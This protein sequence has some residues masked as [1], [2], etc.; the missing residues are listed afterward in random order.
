MFQAHEKE[1]IR[2]QQEI[3]IAREQK[4]IALKR[5]R[6][7]HVTQLA[8]NCAFVSK[9]CDGICFVYLFYLN[10]NPPFLWSFSSCSQ[11]TIVFF[12]TDDH[13]QDL[14]NKSH[15]PDLY[16]LGLDWN[17]TF[18]WSLLFQQYEATYVNKMAK[19]R[20]ETESAL[21]E[22][23]CCARNLN[24][25]HALGTFLTLCLFCNAACVKWNTC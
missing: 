8:I 3:D 20:Q 2:L 15:H 4:E 24:L 6:N 1:V 10:D 22:V 21:Q 17:L 23:S 13:F 7:S 12:S 18:T 14:N 9:W 5:V 19:I 16:P 11:S 25:Y